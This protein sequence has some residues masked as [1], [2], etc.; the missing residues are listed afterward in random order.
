MFPQLEKALVDLFKNSSP[1]KTASGATTVDPRI[2]AWFPAG[3]VV[4]VP[5]VKDVATIYRFSVT[6]RP[7][8]WSYPS[9]LGDMQLFLRVSSINQL[10]LGTVTEILIGSSSF[11]D[12]TSITTDDLSVKWITALTVNDGLN[13]GAPT[14]PIHV[15]NFSFRFSNVFIREP[16]EDDDE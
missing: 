3:D 11:L 8:R 14:Q 4:F 7:G 2:Y 1:Y 10:K 6:G 16:V 12:K 5:G 13:E 9:Q 15:R